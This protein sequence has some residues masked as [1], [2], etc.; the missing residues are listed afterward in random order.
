MNQPVTVEATIRHL[1]AK[2]ARMVAIEI[3]LADPR[4]SAMTRSNPAFTS[5]ARNSACH[6][7]P[8]EKQKDMPQLP[9]VGRSRPPQHSQPALR[10][11][12]VCRSEM[13]TPKKRELRFRTHQNRKGAYG[14]WR[15]GSPPPRNHHR[16]KAPATWP[17]RGS[18]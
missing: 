9:C 6:D 10:L 15:A 7:S 16:N 12:S 14:L 4:P 11:A 3:L 2:A 18:V 5:C 1:P 13:H 8:R 17:C